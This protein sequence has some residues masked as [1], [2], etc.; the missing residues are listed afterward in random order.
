MSHSSLHLQAPNTAPDL[1]WVLSAFLRKRDGETE[2]RQR[3]SG[4]E[5]EPEPHR[6]GWVSKTDKCLDCCSFPGI[7]LWS[8]NKEKDWCVVHG[9]GDR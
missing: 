3:K 5:G 8:Y 2:K 1:V 4:S 7:I 9:A 6:T